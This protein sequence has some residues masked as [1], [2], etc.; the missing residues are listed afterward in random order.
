MTQD[1]DDSHVFFSRAMKHIR[2]QRK[3]SQA[4]L[5]E[6]SKLSIV[7]INHV[8]GVKR[9]VSLT[10]LEKI[11][12]SLNSSVSEMMRSGA[13]LH[14]QEDSVTTRL[15]LSRNVRKF[16]EERGLS[17]ENLASLA[18]VSTSTVA[19]IENTRKAATIDVVHALAGAF[20]VD[21]HHLFLPLA[22][23]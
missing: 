12:S 16:R 14:S 11:A 10:T 2:L 18:G 1:T 21:V 19:S 5:A 15:L 22:P 20:K 8:E 9:R 23:E 3:L 6:V 13:I 17:Q 7:T 4:E